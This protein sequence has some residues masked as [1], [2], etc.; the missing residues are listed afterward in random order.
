MIKTSDF[1]SSSDCSLTESLSVIRQ[2]HVQ[3]HIPTGT[4]TATVLAS[5]IEL[6]EVLLVA[7]SGVRTSLAKDIQRMRERPLTLN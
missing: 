3:L 7:I 6:C 2:T 1:R 5:R 4:T